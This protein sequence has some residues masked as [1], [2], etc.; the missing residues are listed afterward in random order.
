MNRELR[1]LKIVSGEARGPGA[2]LAR[3]G[4]ALLEPLYGAAVVLRNRSFDRG[5]RRQ[6]SLGRPVISVGNITV[7]GTGKTPLVAW[8]CERLRETGLTPA[9][10]T[11]G[12]KARGGEKGDE[13]RLLETLLANSV[14]I[15]ANPDRVAGAARV[16]ADRPDVRVFVLDDGFQHRRVRREADLVLID[17]TRPFGYDRLL[18]RGLLREHAGAIRRASALVLTRSNLVD[19][20]VL[21]Q[22]RALV[23]RQSAAPVFECDLAP[24]GFI[25]GGGRTVPALPGGGVVAV[26]GIGNPQ[27]FLSDLGRR[28]VDVFDSITFGDHHHY[29]AHDVALID[30]TAKGAGAVV[31]TTLKDWMKLQSL[32][33]LNDQANIYIARQRPLFPRGQEE[34]LIKLVHEAAAGGKA[35]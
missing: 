2:A 32:W 29:S 25:D 10:L 17:A 5:W 14:P 11:R 15:A 21:A 12:Y 20:E 34:R 3:A 16:L 7:G 33:P 22:T 18:P 31:V 35:L 28:G 6:F 9:V 13:E 26:C 8:L 1:Y 30:R 19:A 23:S 24:D 27:A 4:L